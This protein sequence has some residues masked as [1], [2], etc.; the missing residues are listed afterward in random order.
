MSGVIGWW[1]ANV[2][3]VA[4]LPVDGS[5][6]RYWSYER[7]RG[8]RHE[9]YSDQFMYTAALAGSIARA[10]CSGGFVWKPRE[11]GSF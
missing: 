8:L 9:M 6:S 7:M 5:V 2:K 10:S 4:K 3:P 11:S 1:S